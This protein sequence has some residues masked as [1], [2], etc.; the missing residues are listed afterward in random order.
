MLAYDAAIARMREMI[1]A[2]EI[3]TG[4]VPALT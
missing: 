3:I 1:R 2:G 4:I